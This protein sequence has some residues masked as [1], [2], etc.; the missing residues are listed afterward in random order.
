L[1]AVAT[2]S[3][4]VPGGGPPQ[5]IGARSMLYRM[6]GPL[7]VQVDGAWRGISAAKWR[8]VLAVL[9]VNSG[10]LVSTDELIGEVWPEAA[11]ATAVNLVS[12]YVHRLRRQLPDGSRRLI[13]R[14][15]GYQLLAAPDDIDV[16]Q[17][18]RM[19][20]DGRAALAAR[21]PERAAG[22]LKA[23]EALW[24]GTR[25]FAD[26]PPSPLIT[27]EA[28]R[29]ED[30]RVEALELRI[31][32]DLGCGRHAQVV[33][34][35]RRL[36]ADHPLRE[37]MWAL[38][39]R[40]LQRSG[41][42]AEALEVYAHARQQIAEELGV[43]PSAELRQLYEHILR[44]DAGA[45]PAFLPTA[46]A[47]DSPFADASPSPLI[48]PAPAGQ[49]GGPG[50]EGQPPGP[51][52][53]SR[54]SGPPGMPAAAPAV[55]SRPAGAAPLVAQ[56]PADI[57]DFTGREVQLQTLQDLLGGPAP[58][59][60]GAVI[61]AAVIG[62]GGL[63]KTTLAVHAAHL[64]RSVFPDGQL[65]ANLVGANAH[66]V[67]S[68]DVLARF[69]RDLGVDPARIPV[70]EEERAAL[71][72]S[73]L[74]GQRVLIVLDDARDAAQVRPLLPGSASCA[75]LVTTRNRMPDLAGSRYVDLDVL[76]ADEAWELF[77]GIVGTERAA[78][79]PA[80]TA[81]V[82]AACA[83]LPLAIRIAG[84][85]LAA[86]G[87]WTVANLARRLSDQRR[88]LDELRAGDLAVRACFAVSFTSLPRRPAGRV[89][90]AHAFRL[91][92]LWPG[93]FI[94]LPAAAAL[95]GE[96]EEETADALEELVD[97]QL[98]QCFAPDRYRFHDLLR[99]YAAGRADLEEPEA[100]RQDSML[101]LLTWYLH[102]VEAVAHLVSPHHYQVELAPLVPGCAPLGFA[103]LEE[104]LDWC[105]V[106][107]SNLL[108]ATRQAAASGLPVLA[109]QLPV[110]AFGFFN[111]RT[112]WAEW[113][114]THQIALSS[115][116]QLG[117]RRAEALV[118][119]NLG[120]AFARR[121]MDEAADFFEQALKI[122]CEIG[123]LPGE[124]QTATNLADTYLRQE[125]YDEALNLLRR[126]LAIR[127]Q[128]ASPYSEGVVLN[129]LGEVYLALGRIAE[130][131]PSLEQ[132][133]KI[134]HDIGELR[135]EGYALNNLGTAHLVR[136]QPAQ[137]I[138]AME[139]ALDLRHACGDRLDE[140]H[141]LRDL[142]RAS[143]ANGQPG[144]ARDYLARAV[145]IL[146]DLGDEAQAAAVRGEFRD[147][148]R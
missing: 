61:V 117:D 26:V 146:D 11:P 19:M 129:N 85:R 17:F 121:R 84:A 140:A 126:A 118:L 148:I 67:S 20:R 111:R 75:V 23:A 34:E 136:G 66:P 93:R 119:N 4:P 2:A 58:G 32:A 101:R 110:A 124:A 116:R 36:L 90:P 102:T 13:T 37:G 141:T 147:L 52:G 21:E 112:Y 51:S 82:L 73:T 59:S 50:R 22:L 109:W 27:A 5:V 113:V 122:R 114:E 14:S 87:G 71:F 123:D 106:E 144:P 24:H 43:D 77:A 46:P 44:A 74:V 45:D 137:A 131:V 81:E 57:P 25:A 48:T 120:M 83:G 69:L 94:A 132:A 56:L 98:L 16:A 79:E 40:A 104:A 3:V 72:R 54:P 63:G 143:L 1:R 41:R 30:C 103:S 35:L 39:M 31:Q 76:S 108:T 65:Y 97:A 128:A 68:G 86:R 42:Q 95:L 127:R 125:R 80:A 15:P 18:D 29:L 53:P 38:L 115:V 130:A 47:A 8:T 89:D 92:G 28:G 78:A 100:V 139:R 91:L 55:P 134:F 64:L 60:P 10:Q 7:E 33:P 9:L 135:G 96:P 70:E 133:R 142:V 107:R 99:T 62:A 12:V 49:D 6:L 145:G 88:R 138:P 105:E